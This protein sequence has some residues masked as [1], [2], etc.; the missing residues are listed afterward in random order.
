VTDEREED[1]CTGCGKLIDPECCG[2]GDPR[3]GHGYDGHGFIPLG[4]DC[5]RHGD[6]AD[7]QRRVARM[8]REKVAAAERK[9]VV[10]VV[11]ERRDQ[12]G[13]VWESPIADALD[14]LADE[15]ERAS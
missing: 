6:D 15:L 10:A 2:C 8:F 13:K 1:V 7:E 12:A 11:R 3:K 4:C 14:R 9:R 5:C